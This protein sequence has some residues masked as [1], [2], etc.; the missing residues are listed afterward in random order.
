MQALVDAVRAPGARQPIIATGF[1]WG[2]H[3]GSWLRYRPHDPANQLV[4]GFHAYNSRSCVTV[5]C[6]SHTVGPVAHHVPVV[7]TELGETRCSQ[8]FINSFM[9]WA[10]SAGV[11]YLGWTWTPSGCTAPALIRSWN[12]QPTPYGE[13]L[14]AHLIRLHRR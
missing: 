8:V 11:S 6:W 13:G 4:A 2:N 12:G 9:N 3:L 7:T 14:R 1:D 10:D 5:A